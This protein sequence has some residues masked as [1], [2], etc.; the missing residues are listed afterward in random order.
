MGHPAY[1]LRSA[2]ERDTALQAFVEICDYRGWGLY[3]AHV[4]QTHVRAVVDA[5]VT[6]KR[7]MGDLK[8][9]ASRALNRDGVTRRWSR[10]GSVR[11]LATRAALERAIHYVACEQGEPLSLFVRADRPVGD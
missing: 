2:V 6:G 1:V 5:N 10:L 9:Y 3:A 4:R 8:A 11:E 7:V